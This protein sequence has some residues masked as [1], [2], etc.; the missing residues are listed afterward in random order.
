MKILAIVP[1]YN[2]EKNITGVI[3]SIKNE[4]PQI[5]ILVVNDG[6]DDMTGEIAQSSGL[7]QVVNLS[8][9]LGIGG[10]VQTG[11][12]FAE[13][14]NYDIVFQFDGDGQHIASE[15]EKILAP[16]RNDLADV[17]IG[18]RFCQDH[19]EFKSTWLRRIGI[20]IF[21]ML[22]LLLIKQ[23]FTDNTSGF[24]AYNR[25]AIHFLADNY[26]ADYPEP[27][28][29]VLL[30][31]NDFLLKEVFVH[32][33]ERMSGRSSINGFESIYY[34]IKVLLAVLMTAL[35]PKLL[36]DRRNCSHS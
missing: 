5:D 17:V 11:F 19:S 29:V 20:K 9:N 10:A 24:R 26:P 2:E 36:K 23:K 35:R 25:R 16:V 34:M 21:E 3:E 4:Y 8:C 22:N 6:S 13:K 14:H 28:T 15:I 27:E 33:Q 1:A 30:G 32:M 7:A 31:R 12:K 18:S